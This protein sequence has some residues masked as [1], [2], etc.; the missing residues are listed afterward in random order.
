MKLFKI[1]LA[2]IIAFGL[3]WLL[4][5]KRG[6]EATKQQGDKNHILVTSPSNTLVDSGMVPEKSPPQMTSVAQPQTVP[7]PVQVKPLPP[8]TQTNADGTNPAN[9]P[10]D[11]LSK[12]VTL[13]EYDPKN[14]Q[15]ARTNSPAGKYYKQFES[16]LVLGYWDGTN[17]FTPIE[18]PQTIDISKS[19]PISLPYGELPPRELT[20][21]KYTD[22]EGRN[23]EEIF[24][25][26]TGTYR[27]KVSTPKNP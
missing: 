2:V 27:V 17:T 9:E 21:R 18:P 7:S 10:K 5:G 16:K 14:L 1:V 8:V 12:I 24:D 15:P 3:L 11:K 6:E 20:S 25:P 13:K 4:F 19:Y 26:K 23:I 22:S